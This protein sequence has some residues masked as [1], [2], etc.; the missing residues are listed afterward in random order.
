M[1]KLQPGIWFFGPRQLKFWANLGFDQ[2]RANPLGRL[3]DTP[4]LHFGF[5]SSPLPW[6]TKLNGE[7]TLGRQLDV[8]ADRVGRGGKSRWRPGL[9]FALP[10]GWAVEL[11]QR[12]NRAW[13]RGAL[14]QPA[15]PTPAGARWPCCT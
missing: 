2:Q 6:L 1:R 14:G 15:L 8:E 9:R 4:A 3:H 13:V 12:W 7:L 11:D 10:H 5:E